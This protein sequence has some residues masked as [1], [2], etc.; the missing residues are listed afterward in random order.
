[1]TPVKPPLE[2][3][4]D[5]GSPWLINWFP[6]FTAIELV[7]L[8]KSHHGYQYLR[9]VLSI[10]LPTNLELPNEMRNLMA[11]EMKRERPFYPDKGRH[12]EGK[13]MQRSMNIGFD[14]E[15]RHSKKPKLSKYQR[16]IPQIAK[17]RGMTVANVKKDYEQRFLQVHRKAMET[18]I[19]NAKKHQAIIDSQSP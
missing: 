14:I 6:L 1:M 13:T 18:G 12:G 11:K 19:A 8:D 3:L 16:I 7:K 4:S 10:V 9:S 17:E 2:H 5:T 15:E